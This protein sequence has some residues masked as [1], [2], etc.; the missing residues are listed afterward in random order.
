MEKRR[1]L[2]KV[3]SDIILFLFLF[4]L[5]TQLGRHFF[6]P[7]SYLSGQRIDYLAPTLYLTDLLI[8][9]IILL[10]FRTLIR[11]FKNK[12]LLFI[13][14]ALAINIFFATSYETVVYRYLKILEL[15]AVF[16]I[17]YKS[18][19]DKKLVSNAFLAGALFQTILAIWQ[20][21]AKSSVQ[22]FFYFFGERYLTLSSPDI[23]KASLNGIEFLRSYATFSHPNSMAGFYLLVYTFF[24]NKKKPLLLF[25]CTILIFLSFSKIA[26]I[27]FLL[28]NIIYLFKNLSKNNCLP[29]D[30]SKLILFI[31]ASLVFLNAQSD[32]QSMAKRIELAKQALVII[33]QNPIWGMGL[34]NYLIAQKKIGTD[35]LFYTPQP[36]HNI[37][38]LIIS[39]VGIIISGIIFFFL[40]KFLARWGI[41]I[42]V[43]I[44][45]GFFD[46]YWLTLQQNLL[47][48]GVI[49]GFTTSEFES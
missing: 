38:L 36:V 18:I 23:A 19:F 30:F 41:C 11:F 15:I 44:W 22:G 5:P 31:V 40:R 6:F 32:P 48:M 20:F 9:F 16:V 34:G 42:L 35:L 21:A 12:T 7:W 2:N 25:L 1:S 14:A 49:L 13:L 43:I 17:F 4:L 24:L 26:I 37:F 10:N 8:I 3:F 39:E 29:C 28:I 47:L 33:S 27:G 46:H 45:T